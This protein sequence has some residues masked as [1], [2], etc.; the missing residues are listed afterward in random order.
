MDIVAHLENF[1]ELLNEQRTQVLERVGA[2]PVDDTVRELLISLDE[3]IEKLR[4]AKPRAAAVQQGLAETNRQF[5]EMKEASPANLPAVSKWTPHDWPLSE[6]A[7]QKLIARLLERGQVAAPPTQPV[8]PRP[9]GSDVADLTSAAWERP[10]L[11]KPSDAKMPASGVKKRRDKKP[12]AKDA[13][14]DVSGMDSSSWD[15]DFD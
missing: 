2:A 8:A 12:G 11:K 14:G 15:K 4:S 10:T 7:V 1:I 3:T 6:P 9:Q 5:D 13:K